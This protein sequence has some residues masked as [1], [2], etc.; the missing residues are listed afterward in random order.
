VSTSS[1]VR[2]ALDAAIADGLPISGG[3]VRKRLKQLR[4]ALAEADIQRKPCTDCGHVIAWHREGGC[5]GDLLHCRCLGWTDEPAAEHQAR[6]AAEPKWICE[7][8]GYHNVGGICTHCGRLA[9]EPK[10]T[11]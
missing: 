7:A 6:L 4:K 1:E 9:A 2:A 8:C 3:K 5:A 10:E 11:P